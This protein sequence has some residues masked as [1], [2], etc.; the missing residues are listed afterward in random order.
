M[1]G[2]TEVLQL[3]GEVYIF[4]EDLEIL[5]LPVICQCSILLLLSLHQQGYTVNLLLDGFMGKS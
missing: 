1:R 4:T 3:V 2:T 5:F